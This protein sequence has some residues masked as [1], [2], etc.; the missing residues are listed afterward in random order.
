MNCN[1]TPENK[2]LSRPHP[3]PPVNKTKRFFET[4]AVMSVTTVVVNTLEAIF[5]PEADPRSWLH[6]GIF[7]SFYTMFHFL[8]ERV[9]AM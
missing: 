8:H 2:D 3:R 7:I 6:Y 1:M 9:K 5:L 4:V